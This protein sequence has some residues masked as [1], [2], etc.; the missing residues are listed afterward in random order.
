MPDSLLN[1]L[2]L[3][4]AGGSGATEAPDMT[5]EELQAA[6]APEAPVMPAQPSQPAPVAQKVSP[7]A[8]PVAPATPKPTDADMAQTLQKA[9]QTQRAAD[10]MQAQLQQRQYEVESQL[11]D[12]DSQMQAKDKVDPDRFWNS[13][14]TGDKIMVGLGLLLGGVGS[15]L[16]GGANPVIDMINK[17]IDRDLAAQKVD[18]ETALTKKKLALEKMKLDLEQRAASIPDPM[19]Q[20]QFAKASAELDKSLL[21][22]Q[23]KRRDLAQGG[24]L[25]AEE[26]KRVYQAQEGLRAVRAMRRALAGGQNTFAL[27]GDND[28]TINER[29]AIEN[30][31]RIQSGGAINKAEEDR[32]KE[33]LPKT[34]NSAKEQERK[35]AVQERYFESV[36]SQANRNPEEVRRKEALSSPLSSREEFQIKAAEAKGFSR[37]QAIRMLRGVK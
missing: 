33:M 4:L 32:F 30:Y 35:L 8:A 34:T 7:F 37:E 19:K 31:G 20:L 22:I 18:L 28:Y 27:I 1:A 9:D 17:A 23:E 3:G 6:S 16:T 12:L 5:A 36:I 21:D 11:A 10:L 15:G 24:K 25:G 2:T 29:V 13:K 14:S 26:G